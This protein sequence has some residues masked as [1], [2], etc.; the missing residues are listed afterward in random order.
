MPEPEFDWFAWAV[1][2]W[3]GDGSCSLVNNRYFRIVAV[4]KER[5]PLDRLVE[6]FGGKVYDPTSK[7]K[8]YMWMTRG[9]HAC[10]VAERM[11][12]FLSKKRQEQLMPKL[13]QAAQWHSRQLRD[14]Q[15]RAIYHN[16]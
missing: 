7:F 2:F 15:G 16:Q 14:E 10:I 12:P 8:Y 5:E 11:M 4:Q 1:G 9:D 6:V 3:E 13:Q